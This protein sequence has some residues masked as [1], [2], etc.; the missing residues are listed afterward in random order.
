MLVGGL[1]RDPQVRGDRVLAQ[2]VGRRN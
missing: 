2:S 1:A